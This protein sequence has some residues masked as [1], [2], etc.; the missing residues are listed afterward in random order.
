G[1]YEVTVTVTDAGSLTDSQAISVTV[2]NV[3]EAPTITS[4]G[5]GATAAGNAAENKTA[6]TTVTAADS[7]AGD[8]KTFSLT[9]TDAGFFSIGSSSDV[10]TFTSARD[11]VTTRRASDVGI[12]EVTVT[13]TDAGT[14]TDS[15]AISVTVTNVNEAPTITSNG[16]GAT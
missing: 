5:G 13:V 4:N 7:D 12:Y 16:G 6:D 14:L 15:Q 11:F 10:L 8:T 2:T 1:I 9:V 3:N